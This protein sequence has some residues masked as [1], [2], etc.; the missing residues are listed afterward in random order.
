MTGPPVEIILTP[1]PQL[2]S[3]RDRYVYFPDTAEVP[4]QQ[5]VNIRNR[6]FTIG[7]LVDIPAPG[8]QGVLFAQGARFGGHALYIKDNRLH[9]VNNFV[10]VMEQKI[11]GNEDMPDRR[12]PDPVR[13]VRQR[14]GGSSRRLHR[15]HVSLPR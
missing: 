11:D 9:Y 13:L 3:A 15:D 14:R 8:A 2:A 6:S 4:E 1:R 12:E 10:G 7:A 5:A